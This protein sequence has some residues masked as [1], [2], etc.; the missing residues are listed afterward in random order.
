MSGT[1]TKSIVCVPSP[2]ISGGLPLGDPLH[3]ADQDLGVGAVDVHPRPVDVEVA[4]RD[5]VEAAHRVV[6]AQQA[7]VEGLGGA[8]EGVVGVGVMQLVGR[9]LVRR[10][11]RR[12]PTRRRP[13]C[14]RSACAAAST[15]LKVPSTSTS[16]ARRG[17]SAHW[18]MRIAAWWKTTS[19]P[20]VSSATSA[21]SRTSPSTTVTLP[22]CLGPVEVL[23]P[24]AD[25]VVE[26][27]DLGGAAP[28]PAGRR[29]S[30][31]SCRHRRL[32]ASALRR[33]CLAPIG[34]FAVMTACSHCFPRL[35]GWTCFLEVLG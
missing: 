11:R 21:R 2:K 17:S 10:G 35:D 24:P 4:E 28:R 15:T 6:A 3:P 29:G 14:A 12:T 18:V 32:P 31:R 25:E 33:S 13:A 1:Q 9:E 27:D 20:A 7:L 30:S 22:F 34:R 5:V 16:S 26:H 19:M 8:V 23:A